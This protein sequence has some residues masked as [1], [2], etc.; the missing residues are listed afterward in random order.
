MR[1]AVFSKTSLAISPLLADSKL[2]LAGVVAQLAER[3]VRN[4]KVRGSTPLGS[5]SLLIK[6]LRKIKGWQQHLATTNP[7]ISTMF[8]TG[9]NSRILRRRAAW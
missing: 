8:D 6:H 2:S 3:L 4:E 7:P 1:S 5:T 9:N